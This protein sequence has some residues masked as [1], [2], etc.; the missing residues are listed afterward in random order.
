MTVMPDDGID[1]TWHNTWDK[2]PHPN[3]DDRDK[4]GFP[5][6]AC[7]FTLAQMCKIEDKLLE[8]KTKH[9]TGA[10][11]FNQQAQDLV[12]NF[13]NHIGDIR[14]EMDMMEENPPPTGAPNANCT[15]E[16]VEWCDSKGKG[17]RHSKGTV[18]QMGIWDL[19]KHFYDDHQVMIKLSEGSGI[20]RQLTAASPLF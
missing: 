19:V 7:D 8:H 10:W 9:S 20:V 14:A 1:C 13:E 11:E 17:N 12:I 5:R 16:L 4:N 6:T 2:N 15:R 3:N 18:Q